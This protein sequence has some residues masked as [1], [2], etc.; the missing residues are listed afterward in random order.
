MRHSANATQ[1][2]YRENGVKGVNF[3][4]FSRISG[5]LTIFPGERSTARQR[6]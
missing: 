5:N 2:V 1:E 3:S 6:K 4:A